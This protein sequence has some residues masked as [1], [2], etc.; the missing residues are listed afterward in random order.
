MVRNF[1]ELLEAV[2]SLKGRRYVAIAVAEDREVLK[3]A[4]G[5]MELGVAT[6]IL[7]GDEEKIKEI[8]EEIDFNIDGIVIEHENNHAAAALKA[9]SLVSSGYADIVMK[10]LVKTQM[11]LRAVLDRNVGLRTDNILSHV[12]VFEIP[13][14]EGLLTITDC[15]MNIAPGIN[16]KQKILANALC[17]TRALGVETAYVAALGAVETVNTDMPATIDA[18]ALSIMSARG[19]IKGA[20]VDGPLGLDNAVS[21]EAAEH[22]GIKSEVSGRPDILLVPDIESGNMIYKTLVYLGN[23]EIA[24]VVVGAA[25][26]IVLTSRADSYSARIYSVALSLLTVCADRGEK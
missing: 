8:A 4:K 14:R 23:A 6:P 7:V 18:A 17:V 24:G 1:A 13:G 15:A 25:A 26:P 12:A 5:I 16:S 3:A 22:K 20:V 9:V 10:G 2:K 11:F 21:Y 19:Q